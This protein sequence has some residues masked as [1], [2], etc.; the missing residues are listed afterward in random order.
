MKF[1][2]VATEYTIIDV[3]QLPMALKW[4]RGRDEVMNCG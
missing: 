3:T 2:K 1:K 4:D